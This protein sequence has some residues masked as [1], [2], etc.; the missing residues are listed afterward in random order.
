MRPWSNSRKTGPKFP[1]S[2]GLAEE[3]LTAALAYC[4]LSL[5]L[6]LRHLESALHFAG[7]PDRIAPGAPMPV[8]AW[9]E[10]R[11]VKIRLQ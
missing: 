9:P 6:V 7:P 10:S 1:C 11:S 3:D 8:C 5:A 2:A 4:D